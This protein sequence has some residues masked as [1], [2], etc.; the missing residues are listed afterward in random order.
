MPANWA[1]RRPGAAEQGLERDEA[2]RVHELSESLASYTP[3]PIHVLQRVV[4]ELADLCRADQCI[5]FR[6]E[7]AEL[8]WHAEFVY[9]A[10]PATASGFRE[11]L[12]TAPETWSRFYP[13]T[14]A[15]YRNRVVRPKA[16]A[17]AGMPISGSA[18]TFEDRYQPK[19]NDDMGVMVCD[20]DVA[21]AWLGAGRGVVFTRREEAIFGALVDPLRVRLL[22]EH[23]LGRVLQTEA[24]LVAA[25]EAIPT[26]TFLLRGTS[27]EYANETGR[28]MLD[29]DRPSLVAQ[30]KTSLDAR[31]DST[32]AL[33]P[34][35]APGASSLV[36]AVRRGGDPTEVA[37]R[38]A[39]MARRHGLTGRQVDVIALLARGYAN[40]T[41]ADQLG[42]SVPTI[43]NHVTA[44]LGKVA[45]DG[46][47]ALVARFWTSL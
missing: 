15:E 26:A 19:D 35:V 17:P 33:T 20:E 34:I 8:G 18:R 44:I 10:D 24:A 6:C 29:G 39:A 30:L 32:F 31:E 36:L 46:R 28:L 41:I 9:A 1:T 13:H 37:R 5:A 38:A 40:K 42:C 7:Y 45:A 11:Y 21:L 47:A 2:R 27:I 12:K 25:L 14:P 23:Q 3:G 43:E 16:L 22:L 4:E